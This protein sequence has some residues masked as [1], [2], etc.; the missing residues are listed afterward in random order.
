MISK[1]SRA[2]KK[3]SGFFGGRIKQSL[4]VATGN[5]RGMRLSRNG[6]V[7]EASR[8]GGIS[9][10][11]LLASTAGASQPLLLP[12]PSPPPLCLCNLWKVHSCSLHSEA[13]VKL[14]ST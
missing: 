13:L 9:K 12:S 2:L 7:C 4:R 14:I 8:T 1:F 3:I 6:T 10:N 11:Q 5:P